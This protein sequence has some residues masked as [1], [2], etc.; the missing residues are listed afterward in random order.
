[1]SLS[2]ASVTW[3]YENGKIEV[4]DVKLLAPRHVG[5]RGQLVV[6]EDKSLS[7]VLLAGASSEA[8]RW[9]PEATTRVF[10]LEKDGLYWAE[11]EIAGTVHQPENNLTK[12]IWAVLKRHP[13]TVAGLATRG[14][15]WWLGDLLHT[16]PQPPE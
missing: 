5:L 2:E 4:A 12:Q 14:L 15:S 6:H 9:L 13:L 3:Q 8:L 16:A 10:T 11:V 1:M 7:G